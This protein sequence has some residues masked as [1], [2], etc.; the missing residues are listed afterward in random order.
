[1]GSVQ[2]GQPADKAG[3]QHQ[4]VI[5]SVDGQAVTSPDDLVSAIASRRAGDIVKLG[6]IRKGKAMTFNVTLGDRKAIESQQGHDSGNGSGEDSGPSGQG[7]HSFSLQKTYGFDVGGLDAVNRHQFGIAEDRKGVVV[8]SVDPRS[9]A[10][11]RGLQ[12][13][14][15][16]T[17]ANGQSIASVQDF[18]QAARKATGKPLLLY[19]E[20]PQ[21]NQRITLAIPPR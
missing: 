19:I 10:T 4:D 17:E 16:I 12:A 13:G 7:S 8:T 2:Q 15:I 1:V 6:V 5:T 9:P 18:T 11:D 14:M 20:A 3:I 21:G